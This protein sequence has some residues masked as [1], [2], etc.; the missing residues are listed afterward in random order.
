[1]PAIT[2]VQL[3]PFVRA[4]FS[5]LRFDPRST[6]SGDEVDALLDAARHA[7]SAGNSQ[8]WSFIVGRRGDDVHRRLTAHL[9]RSS[10]IWAA[11]AG[12]LLANLAHRNVEGSDFEYSEF[13]QYDLGQALA[14][15]TFQ[16]YEM[17]MQVHQFRAFDRAAVADEFQVPPHWEVTSMAAI[18]VPEADAR[19]LTGAGT[20][21]ERMPL[22][23]ITWARALS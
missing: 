1:M 7:P 3:R 18:G 17:G 6:V 16:A 9:A 19:H 2:H 22:D 10:S 8:P 12:L 20:S 5:P 11:D 14:H 21:R 15:L 4:R 13:A 23:A